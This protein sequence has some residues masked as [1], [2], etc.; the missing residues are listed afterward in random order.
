M[1]TV[2]AD[3]SAIPSHLSLAYLE[4]L[5]ADY[6][7]DPSSASPEWQRYFAGLINGEPADK[8]PAPQ[9]SFRSYSVFNPP[10][11]R[12]AGHARREE[13]GVAGRQERVDA[14][15]RSFRTRGHIIARM[16]PLEQPKAT[17]PELDPAYHGLT[18][19]DLDR[20]FA[21]AT[22][23]PDRLLPLRE[24]IERL[25]NTYCRSI[26]VQ[27]MHIDDYG[28]RYWLQERMERTQNRLPLGRR[29]QLRILTRLTDAVVF[30][31]FIRKKFIGAKSFS[32]E[33]C[34][35]LIPLLDLAI[36]RAGEQGVADIVLG[37][38]H[39]GRLNVLANIIG[40][41]PREIF[42]EFEDADPKLHRGGGDVK[43]HLG[44][45]N[46][47]V[48]ASGKK[49]HL[50]LC[51]NPSHLEFVNPVATGRVR[52]RQDCAGDVER[53]RSLAL[54]IHGDAAF[55][56]E[57]VVQ[58]TLNLSRLPGYTVGGTLH[59]IVNNQIGFTTPPNEGRSTMYATSVA[60]MLPAPIFHINGEDPEA[61]A[62]CVLLALEFRARFK[63][64]VVIDMY[65]YRR[66][67]H[68]ESDEPTFTQPV[69]YRRIA[70]RKPVREGYLEHLLKL[71]EVTRAEADEIAE[72]RHALLEKNLAEAR[73]EPRA[74]LNG[75]RSAKWKNYFGGPE[76]AEET[77]T[78]LPKE[79]LS[80]WL[81]AQ[82]RLPADFHPHPKI[83]RLLEAR[84]KMAR[85]DQALDWSAA[86]ALA[87]ASLATAGARV[88]MSGEDSGRGTFSHRH[89]ILHDFEDGHLYT[90]LQHLAADQAPVDIYNSPLSETGVLGFEYGYSLDCPGG[91]ILWEAQF[92]DFVNAAQVIVDQFILSAEKKWGHL[93]GLVLLLPHGMEGM[94]PEHSSARPERFLRLAAEDNVQV[95]YP[96]TP[97]QYF[98][99]LRRQAL[100]RWRKPLVVMAPKSLLRHPQSVSALDEL[101]AG[102]FRRI[103]PDQRPEAAAARVKRVLL[104]SGKIY[105]ELADHREKSRRDDVALLR[106]EQPYPLPDAVWQSVLAGY[107]DGTPVLWVQEEPG[108]MGAWYD[109]R[110]RFGDRLFGRWPFDGVFRPASASP[111]GGSA[112]AH[113][114]EQAALIAKAFGEKSDH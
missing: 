59:V 16:D 55:I 23:E 110:V 35:S 78:G 84:R 86:E 10:A 103:I 50:S 32:L 88:R 93:S 48:T 22:M 19:A 27:F 111:A 107:R 70:G 1:R 29:E 89:A 13:P 67:G 30:E 12:R 6:L 9:P 52:A 114:R 51:F 56:A 63:L 14:L 80:A 45:S 85:G 4:G 42:R 24:I 98:H 31:E 102:R 40:K 104:C 18:D 68:N 39:R 97:A 47:W 109:F 62:Q 96:T 112:N 83:Q 79:R 82:T 105:F 57:G 87:F 106:V 20:P 73:G 71:G 65:G 25:R 66:L 100:Q 60:K 113:K 46:D 33:G 28:M 26:G 2:M 95:A 37:M 36:E 7:R 75:L 38:A 49:V 94:G 8:T 3:K 69:L 5:Y 34:E 92:G 77:E 44:Y 99:L 90:P 15:I 81:D 43:Y 21:C 101:A 76:P 61:V 64:D 74:Q 11:S 53:T 108:N 91:L 58:E 41:S 72:R 17:P 54:L